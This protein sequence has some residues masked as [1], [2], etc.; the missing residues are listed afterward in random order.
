MRWRMED[1]MARRYEDSVM[2]S[3]DEVRDLLKQEL[4]EAAR[5][6]IERRLPRDGP[7]GADLGV[8]DAGE[9]QAHRQQ[10]WI[11]NGTN[12]IA[13]PLPLAGSK[14][15]ARRA[16]IFLG[17]V[18]LSMGLT[19]FG[20]RQ[21]Y[22]PP[23][24]PFGITFDVLDQAI[25]GLELRARLKTIEAQHE[26]A[27]QASTQ[28][29]ADTARLQARVLTLEQALT[30]QRAAAAISPPPDPATTKKAKRAQKAKRAKKTKRRKRA[31]TRRTQQRKR[32]ASAKSD[33]ALDDLIGGL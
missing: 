27:R 12:I 10:R 11:D 23:P 4:P 9:I 33:K 1:L 5:T 14:A 17:G 26:A 15:R 22:E 21:L 18:A 29:K 28:A 8:P 16:A 24:T 3:L 25:E 20:F 19:F 30:T 31:A 32:A 13:K 6:Q 2:V 7:R